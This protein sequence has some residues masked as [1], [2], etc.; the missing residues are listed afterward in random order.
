MNVALPLARVATKDGVPSTEKF[1]VPVGTPVLGATG[2]TVAVKVTA[3]PK[4]P[5]LT[6][7]VMAVSVAAVTCFRTTSVA[8]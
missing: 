6:D 4:T 1:T 3:W 5:L 2:V 8:V 7:E